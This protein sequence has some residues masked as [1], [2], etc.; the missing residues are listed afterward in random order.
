MSDR[1][2][3][4]DPSSALAA[5]KYSPRAGDLVRFSD[6][7]ADKIVAEFVSR[8][9]HSEPTRK[10]VREQLTGDENYLLLLFARR[11]A[12]A[13]VRREAL[14]LAYDAIDALTLVETPRI[15]FR[16]LS[17]DFPLFVVRE[18]GGDLESVIDAAVDSSEPGTAQAFA[19]KRERARFLTLR[20]CALVRV[21]SSYGIGFMDD[22]TGAASPPITLAELAV[23][24][25]D[26][27]EAEGTYTDA[28][29]HVSRLPPV[30]FGGKDA[31]S[32]RV[33]GCVS[34]SLRH[35]A[36]DTPFSH[37]LLVFLAELADEQDTRALRD[38]IGDHSTDDRPRIGLAERRILAIFIGGSA[39][40]GEPSKESTDSLLRFC[41]IAGPLLRASE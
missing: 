23:S 11:R 28:S 8:T 19:A 25:A 3:S 13:A 7:D 2:D 34:I 1:L 12:V 9:S 20:D 39:T 40:Q 6:E 18:L 17:V 5:V 24:L 37:G 21:S 31:L 4:N 22:W 35:R 29:M 41:T 10:T 14:E 27:I 26:A 15:D 16:D 32:E 38:R 33:D 30:W 36:S